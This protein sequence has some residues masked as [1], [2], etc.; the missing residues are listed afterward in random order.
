[1]IERIFG[2]FKSRFLI[3]KSA[4]SFSFK[5]Q[6][7]LVL[8]FARCITFYVKN[9]DQIFDQ[10]KQEEEYGEVGAEEVDTLESQQQV[11]ANNWRNMIASNMWIDAVGN[12]SQR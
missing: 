7:E 11:Y 8:A 10:R 3:F 6:V 2:I 12:G 4:P 5:T 1:M 9:A